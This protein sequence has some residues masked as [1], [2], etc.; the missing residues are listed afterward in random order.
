[1]YPDSL[2]VSVRSIR[3][4][5]ELRMRWDFATSLVPTLSSLCS[6]LA[7]WCD[8]SPE[9][10][11]VL[12]SGDSDAAFLGHVTTRWFSIIPEFTFASSCGL[13]RNG[14]PVPQLVK[15]HRSERQREGPESSVEWVIIALTVSSPGGIISSFPDTTAPSLLMDPQ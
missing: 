7:R 9:D 2:W 10:N 5:Y 8:L 14:S 4:W 6:G 11:L 15:T 12:R 13:A 3:R 1:M